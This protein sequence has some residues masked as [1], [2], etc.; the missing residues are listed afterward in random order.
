MLIIT[1]QKSK[2]W[3]V[4]YFNAVTGLSHGNLVKGFT[5]LCA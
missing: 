4:V 2:A 5:K 3:S 1:G